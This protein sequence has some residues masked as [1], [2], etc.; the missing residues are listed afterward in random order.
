MTQIYLVHN[1]V[2]NVKFIAAITKMGQN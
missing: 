1:C 2:S